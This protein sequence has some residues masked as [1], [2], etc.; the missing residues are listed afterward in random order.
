M[1]VRSSAIPLPTAGFPEVAR[2][3]PVYW[4]KCPGIALALG[5]AR[6]EL[7]MLDRQKVE[8]LLRRRFPNAPIDQIAAA[9]NG[10]MGLEDEW[11]EIGEAFGRTD[12]TDV[13]AEHA[14]DVRV[15]RRRV[16]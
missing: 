3:T 7:P 5:P 6:G 14:H 1:F 15:F 2:K 16:Q 12:R 11:E 13:S 8:T 10:L 9:A 4:E